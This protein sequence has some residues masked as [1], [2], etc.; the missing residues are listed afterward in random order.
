[1]NHNKCVKSVLCHTHVLASLSEPDG[2]FSN[3]SESTVAILMHVCINAHE[4]ID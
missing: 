1:M 4:I 3:E 2:A